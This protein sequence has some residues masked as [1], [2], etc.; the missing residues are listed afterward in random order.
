MRTLS[1][2]LGMHTAGRT[3]RVR[4]R[5]VDDGHQ[6]QRLRTQQLLKITMVW[7]MEH[8]CTLQVAVCSHS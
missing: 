4:E 6:V 1:C 7:H 2:S 5:Q 3:H 8:A